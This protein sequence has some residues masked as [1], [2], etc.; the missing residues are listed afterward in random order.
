MSVKHSKSQKKSSANSKAPKYTIIEY[1]SIW[2]NNNKQND[3]L[4]Y[5]QGGAQSK[6]SISSK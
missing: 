6:N 3:D 4:I 5:D 2:A 1:P